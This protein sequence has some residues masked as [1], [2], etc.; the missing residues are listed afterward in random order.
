MTTSRLSFG[1]STPI[2]GRPGM[3]STT[4]TL[5]TH[6]L[7]AKSVAR[8]EIFEAFVPSGNSNSKRVIT[9]PGSFATTRT[10]FTP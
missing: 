6:I 1:I 5:D 9:G 8:P 3:T 4:R 7:R 10:L 2:V